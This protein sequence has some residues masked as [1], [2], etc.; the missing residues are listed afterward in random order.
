[1]S[2]IKVLQAGATHRHTH[3]CAVLSAVTAEQVI[4]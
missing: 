3:T 2:E 1:M 4:N